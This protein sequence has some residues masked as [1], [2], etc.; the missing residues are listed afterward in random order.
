MTTRAELEALVA[1]LRS[2]SGAPAAAP[3][4]QSVRP[5]T[6]ILLDPAPM[7]HP[8]CRICGKR[9]PLGPCPQSQAP[10]PKTATVSVTPPPVTETAPGAKFDPVVWKRNYMREYMRKRRAK[11]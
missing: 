2:L 7:Q 4:A 6:P 5:L 3:P 1:S 8:K 9:H 11:P 10:I